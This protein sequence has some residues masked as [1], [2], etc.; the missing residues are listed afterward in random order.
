MDRSSEQALLSTQAFPAAEGAADPI[1]RGERRRE[2][3]RGDLLGRYL[4]IDPLGAGGMG[5]VVAAYDPELD[6]KI[7]LKL[8]REDALQGP[9]AAMARARLQRE[10]QA[11]ARLSHPNVVAVFDVG[12][13]DG[14]LFVA[15]EYV[16]QTLERWLRA[17]PWSEV[18][19]G[20]LQA[21]RGLGA[22]HEAGLVHRDFKPANVLVGRDGR[23]RVTDFGL[24]AAIGA[25][26]GPDLEPAPASAHGAPGS[27]P[28]ELALTRPTG[29]C[30]S[31]ARTPCPSRAR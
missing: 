18:L 6:R 29:A 12:D 31:R 4:V 13:I 17:R 14:Q 1:P 24:V 27:G 8:I 16:E 11:M 20:F 26:Q 10:A 9:G 21:G 25:A 15:M 7:A 3:R 19:D 23:V 28:L 22:A 5:V 2:P 30:P